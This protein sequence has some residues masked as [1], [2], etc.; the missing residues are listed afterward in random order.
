MSFEFD[1]GW[2]QWIWF[3]LTFLNI[4]VVSFVHGKPRQ[5]NN[6]INIQLIGSILGFILLYC[7]GFFN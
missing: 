5:G 1:M 7:G 3:A 2:P 6:S 4:T